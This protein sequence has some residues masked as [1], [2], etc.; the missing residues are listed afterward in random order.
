MPLAGVIGFALVGAGL[1][2]TLFYALYR[3]HFA[4]WCPSCDGR[5]STAGAGGAAVTCDLCDGR[6]TYRV[7]DS[8]P[9]EWFL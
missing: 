2:G 3:V 5:G 8:A 4:P 9:A 7:P 1:L 6:G